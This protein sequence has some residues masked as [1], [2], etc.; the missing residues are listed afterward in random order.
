MSIPLQYC[1]EGP[2]QL[3]C[4]LRPV[5]PLQFE[6]DSQYHDEQDGG[7]LGHG[8]QGDGDELEAPLAEA[9]VPGGGQT[10]R[11][12]FGN[13]VVPPKQGPRVTL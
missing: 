8:V 7:G 4:Y 6:G 13:V 11:G 12:N 2:L 1:T 9:D 10:H 3:L 5:L